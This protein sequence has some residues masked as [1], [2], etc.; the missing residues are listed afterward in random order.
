MPL[1]DRKK[2][3]SDRLFWRKVE[4]DTI[5]GL[6]DVY[7][8]RLTTLQ[9]SELFDRSREFISSALHRGGWWCTWGNPRTYV[10]GD[11][12]TVQ[13]M[14]PPGSVPDAAK[15]DEEHETTPVQRF[16]EAALL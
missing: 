5:V 10:K 3:R 4:R 8:G 15:E 11:R 13:K 9:L 1:R 16:R 6:M 2:Y 14:R 7:E 12:A